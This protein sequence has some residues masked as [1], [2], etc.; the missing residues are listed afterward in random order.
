M[1]RTA[2]AVVAGIVVGLALAGCSNANAPVSLPC[3]PQPSG[4]LCI[5][6]FHDGLSVTDV[7]G[8]LSASGS[9]LAGQTWRLVVRAGG[10]TYPGRT[11]HGNPPLA[12]SC[13][14]ANGST[15]TTGSGCDDTLAADYATSGAFA[16]F[17][18]PKEFFSTVD[19]C[20]AEQVRTAGKW[21]TVAQ[22]AA[23]C[24]TV[25]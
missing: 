21:R 25:S 19:L 11:R 9:P 18:V 14:N 5:K 3:N 1:A 12:I 6:V 24:S 10:R 8:Y 20:V 22:P 2:V 16:G 17:D 13:R 7:I 4:A 15:V 23:A